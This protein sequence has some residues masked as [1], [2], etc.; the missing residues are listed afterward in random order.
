[1]SIAADNSG[2]E[3]M[4]AIDE[5]PPTIGENLAGNEELCKA[6]TKYL[7]WTYWWPYEQLQQTTWNEDRQIDNAWR[8][9]F[10]ARD[11]NFTALT[12]QTLA[13]AKPTPLDGKSAQGQSVAP[14]QQI[15]AVTNIFETLSFEDGLP[16]RATVPPDVEEDVYYRPT[17]E[18]AKALNSII[19]Q[20]AEDVDFRNS[21][22]RMAGSFAKYG[23]AWVHCPFSLERQEVAQKPIQITGG[24]PQVQALIAAAP[25]K[26][27]E[28]TPEGLVFYE[29]R[30]HIRTEFNV[31]HVHDVYVDQFLPCLNM[32]R[33]PAPFVR[34][35]VTPMDIEAN[36]Y[37]AKTN[38]F[39]YLNARRAVEATKGHYCLNQEDM[40][41]MRDRLKNRYNLNDNYGPP[42]RQRMHQRWTCYP[43]LRIDDEGNLDIGEG[44]PCK[45][46]A[47]SGKVEWQAENGEGV[48][49]TEKGP[50]PACEGSGRLRP[51]AKRYIVQFFGGLTL[52]TTCL[53]IQEMPAGMKVPILFGADL[54]EDDASS[55]PMSK[56]GVMLI[57]V[58]QATRAESQ[59]ERGK[60]YNVNRPWI[61]WEDSPS[62]KVQDKNKSGATLLY[63]NDP[64]ELQR[65]EGSNY[66]DG[67]TLLV[68]LDRSDTKIQR[69]MGASDTLLGQI[70]QGRRSALEIGEAT[71]AARNPLVLM[72][73]RL[74]RMIPGKWA[75]S[76][77]SG[78]RRRRRCV[79]P[80][81]CQRQTRLSCRFGRRCTTSISSSRVWIFGYR[82][83]IPRPLWT[84]PTSARRSS[85][86]DC[87]T[88]RCRAI[89]T[90]FTWPFSRV[91]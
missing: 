31:L 56:S 58:E 33:Q 49:S 17:E 24:L 44:T 23:R 79:K 32:E 47:S 3:W 90:K 66:D 46:C 77:S 5:A 86:K 15:Q 34:E 42:E 38:P 48:A 80:S 84:R 11:L 35:F 37:D 65:A 20:N 64:K 43:M 9:R 73:D 12:R 68:Y 57:A 78:W 36:A 27:A 87:R 10:D 62:A 83:T 71:E 19:A 1:M 81:K 50:C 69:I 75:G 61:C 2:N 29:P 70:S 14:F 41:P 40:V 25:D 53:R 67:P 28:M 18:S 59:F 89:R 51:P 55:I 88:C 54:I 7:T 76:S 4:P 82:T 21:Y 6:L 45:Q 8:A 13:E 91:C 52:Q 85:A 16:M 60:E 30:L 63:S 72:V 39:G 22:R 74:N 26:R